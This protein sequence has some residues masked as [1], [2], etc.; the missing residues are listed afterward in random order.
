MPPNQLK[1]SSDFF[2]SESISLWRSCDTESISSWMNYLS[3]AKQLF[4]DS[5]TKDIE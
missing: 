3:D 5:I 2:I 4:L 1:L